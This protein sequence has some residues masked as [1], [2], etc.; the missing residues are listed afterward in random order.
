VTSSDGKRDPIQTHLQ[1]Y[2]CLSSAACIWQ[3]HRVF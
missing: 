2:L 1:H 3:T